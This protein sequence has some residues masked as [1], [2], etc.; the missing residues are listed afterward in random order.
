MR[1][2]KGLSKFI[3]HLLSTRGSVHLS[4]LLSSDAAKDGAESGGSRLKKWPDV[5]IW[6]KS[7]QLS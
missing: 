7:S 5:S 3:L 2:W 6:S 1:K 4:S